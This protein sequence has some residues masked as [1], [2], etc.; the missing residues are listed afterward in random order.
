MAIHTFCNLFVRRPSR[1]MLA[2]CGLLLTAV[3]AAPAQADIDRAAALLDK[4]RFP[5]LYVGGGVIAAGA[6]THLQ[7]LAERLGAP[8]VMSDN[9]LGALSARHPLAMSAL[10][11]L[12]WA[13]KVWA[14]SEI[15]VSVI[16]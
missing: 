10:A 7:R 8:V 3:A 13:P 6:S 16:A 11:V 1:G 4:A 15:V 5:V 9:G 2:L 14:S 12:A